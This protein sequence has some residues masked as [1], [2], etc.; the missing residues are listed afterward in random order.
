M[1]PPEEP[2]V[3]LEAAS[4]LPDGR[5]PGQLRGQRQG[6]QEDRPHRVQLGGHVSREVAVPDASRPGLCRGCGTS[7]SFQREKQWQVR[8]V[9][10]MILADPDKRLT[11]CQPEAVGG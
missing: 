8:V 10:P 4:L 3:S 6:A 5:V 7:H 9:D 1:H 11:L 2:P